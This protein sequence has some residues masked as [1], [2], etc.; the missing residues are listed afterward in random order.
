M[1]TMKKLLTLILVL[2]LF[3]GCSGAS[4]DPAEDPAEKNFRVG[5]L[6]L[7]QHEALGA[8]QQGFEDA[9]KGLLGDRVSFDEQ[10][11][12]GDANNCGIIAN[13][14]VN[15]GVDMIFAV[16]TPSLQASATAT[17]DIPIVAT[18]VTA[19]KVALGMKDWNGTTG[20]NITGTSD[21]APLDQQADQIT[22]IFPDAKKVGIFFCSAEANSVFQAEEIEK[23]LAAKGLETQRFTFADSNDI[24]Q[25]AASA[26]DWADVVYVPTDNMAA[27]YASADQF[28]KPVVAGE[29]GLC[30]KIGCV[31]ISIAYYDIGF[32]AGE[33]AYDILVNGADP[34][35]MKVEEVTKT[36]KKFNPDLCA[37]FNVTVPSDY[38][39]I[40]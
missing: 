40:S 19:F 15:D 23:L 32:R 27:S 21:L 24:A 10:N 25:V 39:S 14:F 7:V 31:T 11:A 12:S 34:A 3:T 4:E 26:C 38:E 5:V 2:F 9:L 20:M 13:Q 22:D 29:E 18:A 1:K 36:A 16:A 30:A 37:K 6:Q 35:S 8:A 28:S 17:A 33:M